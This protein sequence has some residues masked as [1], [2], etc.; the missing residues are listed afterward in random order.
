MA[1]ASK[2]T[3]A[4]LHEKFAEVLLE[5]LEDES[6]K[7][8]GVPFESAEGAP[9]A[10]SLGV[11]PAALNVIRGFLKDNE[12]TG[13]EEEGALVALKEKYKSSLQDRRDIA[14]AITNEI[15]REEQLS[16]LMH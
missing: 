10:V 7:L 11:N 13:G 9:G 15:Q 3:L 2:A 5:V 1:R 12:I 4:R 14:A 8:Q 6:K 16:S